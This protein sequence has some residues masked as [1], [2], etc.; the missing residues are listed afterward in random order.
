MDVVSGMDNTCGRCG[1]VDDGSGHLCIQPPSAANH[2][3]NHAIN[4]VISPELLAAVSVHQHAVDAADALSLRGGGHDDMMNGIQQDTSD[5]HEE[6]MK[7]TE[8]LV[9]VREVQNGIIMQSKRFLDIISQQTNII[10]HLEKRLRMTEKAISRRLAVGGNTIHEVSDSEDGKGAGEH[11]GYTGQGDVDMNEG[12]ESAGEDDE[13]ESEDDEHAGE[14]EDEDDKSAGEDGESAGRN[15][16]EEETSDGRAIREERERQKR[17]NKRAVARRVLE[18][19]LSGREGCFEYIRDVVLPKNI[20]KKEVRML[21]SDLAPAYTAWAVEKGYK[22]YD[23]VGSRAALLKIPSMRYEGNT[24]RREFVFNYNRVKHHFFGGRTVPSPAVSPLMGR[25]VVLTAAGEA[26]PPAAADG[27]PT[28]NPPADDLLTDNPFIN[29]NNIN[30]NGKAYTAAMIEFIKTQWLDN[31]VS[32]I[33]ASFETVHNEYV[34]WCKSRNLAVDSS[35]SHFTRYMK[36]KFPNSMEVAR[37]SYGRR[38]ISFDHI[39]GRRDY[40]HRCK[41]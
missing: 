38:V 36:K 29:N 3:A 41:K 7:V 39:K 19:R 13:N 30:N 14:D 2:V 17:E 10:N 24:R 22:P 8:E 25:R 37:V 35:P 20:G 16:V 26:I 33:T 28:D 5:V 9:M 18:K 23:G 34:E 6:P 15:G 31:G 4:H 12:G 32:F 40:E 1:I 11:S 27:P 21:Y